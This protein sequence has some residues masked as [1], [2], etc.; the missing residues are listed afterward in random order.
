MVHE[1]QPLIEYGF[2]DYAGNT[3][4]DL[5]VDSYNEFT[6]LINRSAGIEIKSDSLTQQERDFYLDQRHKTYVQF[7]DICKNS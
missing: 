6:H 5:W 3:W 7:V 2:K 1:K 4:Y